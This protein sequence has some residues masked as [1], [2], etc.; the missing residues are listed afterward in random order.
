MGYSEHV[1]LTVKRA[2]EWRQ[3]T[4]RKYHDE[5]VTVAKAM[6]AVSVWQTIDE[7]A[8]VVNMKYVSYCRSAG[9]L[10]LC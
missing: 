1:A 5:C 9:V 8:T 10:Q 3:W 6:I 2:G 4:Y 7:H